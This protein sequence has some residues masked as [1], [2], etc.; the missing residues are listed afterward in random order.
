MRD[1]LVALV[2]LGVCAFFWLQTYSIRTPPFAEFQ[3][4][5]PAWFPRLI[6][7]VLAA[8]SLILLV[9]GGGGAPRLDRAALAAALS[10]YRDPLFALG[11]FAGY[12]LLVPLL[13]YVPATAIYLVV[14]QLV[15]RPRRGRALALVTFGSIV[16]AWGIAVLFEQFLHV[17]LPRSTLF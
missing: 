14:M 7:A 3:E 16:F 5:G 9:Q 2:L 1:R 8:F 11:L 15:L 13:G 6:A 17:V 4:L 10:R 12:V